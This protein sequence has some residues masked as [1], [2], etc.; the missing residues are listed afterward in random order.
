M[1]KVGIAGIGFMGW[2][3][4]LAYQ[5][6]SGVEVVAIATPEEERRSGDWTG[7]QGNFGPPGA[8]IDLSGVKTY[9]NLQSML[10]DPDLELDCIDICLPP[11]MHC[12]AIQAAAKAGKH[13]FCEK[14]LALNLQDCDTAVATCKEYDRQ[15]MVGQVLPYFTEF[16]FAR[17]VIASGEYG[18]LLGGSFKRVI[19]D[20]QWLTKFYD[21]NVIGGPLFDLHVHDA[22]FI[23]LL[24]GMPTGVY[25][26]G[27]IRGEVVDY[28]NSIFRFEDSELAVTCTCGVINQQGRPFTHGFE[29]H[30]ERATLQFDF[31]AFAD[32]PESMPLKVLTEDGK[33]HRPELGDGDPVFAFKREIEEVTRAIAENRPSDILNGALARDGIQICQMQSE[34]VKSGQFVSAAD[35][36]K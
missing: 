31:Q 10:A 22:H 17:E 1:T 2:I 8:Q 23:R 36:V 29:I 19:S 11:A 27:R 28:C 12:E 21:P 26:C 30:L 18:K 3:H 24:F 9:E 20:P 34:A 7:I 5:E 33:V 14:P 15:L 32:T 6:L 35:V 4:W 25:S 16:Q 13:V